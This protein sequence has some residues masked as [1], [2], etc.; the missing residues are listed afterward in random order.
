[1]KRWHEEVSRTKREWKKHHDQHVASNIGRSV[2]LDKYQQKP[3]ADPRE[4]ECVCDTQVGRF[5][6]KRGLGC[7]K[8]RCG[9]CKSHKYPV[10]EKTRGEVKSDFRFKEVLKEFNN[11]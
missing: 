3:G 8:V 6:K 1:M 10:R 4:V 11:E 9:V 5:R 2:G 7:G